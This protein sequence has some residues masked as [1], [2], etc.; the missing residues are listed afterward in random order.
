VNETL[1]VGFC[2]NADGRIQISGTNNYDEVDN[3]SVTS[4]YDIVFTTCR[5]DVLASEL[6]GRIH[7]EESESTDN[8]VVAASLTAQNLAESLFEDETFAVLTERTA[9]TGAFSDS[10][11]L[12]PGTTSAS[13]AFAVTTA[14][15]GGSPETIVDHT[16]DVLTNTRTATS[17]ATSTTDANTVNG[18]FTLGRFVGGAEVFKMTMAIDNL[19]DSVQTITA[20]GNRIQTIDGTIGMAWAPEKAGCIAGQM[21]IA[22]TTPRAFAPGGTCPSEG[23]M[24]INNAIITF[25]TPIQ[26]TMTNSTTSQTFADCAA[27]DATGA[28]CLSN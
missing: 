20:G 18:T 7:I 2:D 22:T 16:F 21:T 1:T 15:R 27:M 13:G 24:T 26:V 6:D 12:T 9:L 3:P 4:S 10:D 5:D 17:D 8:N 19:V 28:A 23:V 14:A 11:L 25:G